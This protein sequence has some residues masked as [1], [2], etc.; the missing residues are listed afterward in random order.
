VPTFLVEQYWPGA[1]IE[2]L[3]DALERSP[4]DGA[5][6]QRRNTPRHIGSIFIPDE[7]VVLSLYEAPS[8]AAVGELN[9]RASIPVSRIVEA[10]VVTDD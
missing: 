3:L 6:R 4:D 2:R 1:K 10:I 8:A 7:E 5:D 9:E